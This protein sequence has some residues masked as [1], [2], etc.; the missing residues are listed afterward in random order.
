MADTYKDKGQKPVKRRLKRIKKL[1]P[2]E[3]PKYK[4]WKD[5]N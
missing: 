5:D 3:K 2:V 1:K 4:N